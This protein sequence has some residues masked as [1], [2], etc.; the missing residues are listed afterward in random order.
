MENLDL[1]RWDEVQPAG[2]FYSSSPWL[3]HAERTADPAPFYFTAVDGDRLLATLPAYPLTRD[4][5]FLFCRA[6]TVIDQISRL[7]RG[8]PAGW[9]DCLM[10]S[11][12]CGPRH[13]SHTGVAVARDVG[14]GMRRELTSAL[15]DQAEQIGREQGLASLSFLYTDV[16]DEVLR[17]VLAERGY[18]ALRN[19]TTYTLDIP[20]TGDFADYLAALSRSRRRQV[21][22]DL[23]VLDEAGV[24]YRLQP[25]TEEL[26][27]RLVPLEMQ[28]YARNGTQAA[29]SALLA[30]LTSLS[31]NIPGHT[32]VATAEMGGKLAGFA[33]IFTHGSELYARQAGFDYAVKGTV[34]LYFG[35]IFYQLIRLAQRR[36]LGRIHYSIG[37]GRAKE[38]RG[39][40]GVEQLAYVKSF[41]PQVRREVSSLAELVPPAPSS[42]TA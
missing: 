27:V 17:S 18:A 9:E 28:L 15:A 30:V 12:A 41:D 14:P 22:R 31:R 6:D 8:R 24:T 25:L 11:L 32:E 37:A 29:E 40:T 10:P 5:P 3:C 21:R 42:A 34:P 4:A 26:A 13:S 1:A 38:S 19:A 36:G 2:G 20:G 16:T 7:S 39:S 35:L 23:R 33:L